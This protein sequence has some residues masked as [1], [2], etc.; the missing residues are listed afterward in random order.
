VNFSIYDEPAIGFLP[1]GGYLAETYVENEDGGYTRSVEPVI[2]W[3]VLASGHT[4]ALIVSDNGQA[5]PYSLEQAR[6][7]HPDYPDSKR[8]YVT[9]LNDNQAIVD[10]KGWDDK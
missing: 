4:E 6:V 3:V 7:F 8:W 2:G 10:A 9:G 1:S 5:A